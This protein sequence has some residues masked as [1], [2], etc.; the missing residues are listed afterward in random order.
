MA[1]G[2]MRKRDP[3]AP[4]SPRREERRLKMLELGTTSV[5]Q[6]WRMRA[7]AVG[8]PADNYGGAKAVMAREEEMERKKKEKERQKKDKEDSQRKMFCGLCILIY[9]L[10]VGVSLFF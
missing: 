3:G 4:M 10:P 8:L 5:K 2:Q 6:M 7:V 1:K 9:A